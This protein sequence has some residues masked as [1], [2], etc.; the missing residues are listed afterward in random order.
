MPRNRPPR[1]QCAC[2]LTKPG[3]DEAVLVA[4][5][6]A[7]RA[8]VRPRVTASIVDAVDVDVL[9]LQQ[10]LPAALPLPR[11]Y[12]PAMT[13]RRHLPAPAIRNDPGF[14]RQAP[15]DFGLLLRERADGLAP[16]AD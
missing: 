11:T 1:M 12:L 5:D 14:F 8:R 2:R 9:V 10:D 15:P 3:H 16:K 13:L 4:H 7:C 6:R